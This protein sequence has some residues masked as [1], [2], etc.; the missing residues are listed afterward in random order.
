MFTSKRIRLILLGV[1]SLLV[2][3]AIF[4]LIN[5][6]EGPNLLIVTVLAAVI[7]S[8]SLASYYIIRKLLRRK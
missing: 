3:R 5:D 6:P 1:V 4:F 2:S 7:Y 8:A